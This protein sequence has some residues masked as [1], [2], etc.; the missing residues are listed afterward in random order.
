MTRLTLARFLLLVVMML[1]VACLSRA[2]PVGHAVDSGVR[3]D[4]DGDVIMDDAFE[5]GF[6]LNDPADGQETTTTLKL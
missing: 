1:I 3:Y 2:D 6:D 4:E 5:Q